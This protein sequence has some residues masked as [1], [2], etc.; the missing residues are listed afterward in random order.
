[1]SLGGRVCVVGWIV[2]CRV[3]SSEEI[4]RSRLIAGAVG[5][6][7]ELGYAQTTVGHITRRASV[8]R[9]TFYELFAN[10]EECLTAVLEEI[11]GLIGVE[12]VAAGVGGLPWR[13]R[14]RMGLLVILGFFDREPALARVC[15]V[16]ALRGGAGVLERREEVLAGLA[17]VLDEGR[18]EG[19]AWWGVHGVDGGGFGR[20]GI[21]DCL[22]A[23][24]AGGARAACG[25]GGGA[26]GD[27]RVAL[28]GSGGGAS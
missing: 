21:R 7:E 23:F 28:P 12:F 16:Q 27:D 19:S 3:C 15:V 6:I 2:V 9:R 5:A 11:V 1:M 17:A 8:S 25:F 4:Q 22:C 10:R 14:V 13:E 26:D 24:V 18:L 20:R